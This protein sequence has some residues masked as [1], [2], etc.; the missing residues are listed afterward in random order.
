MRREV[1]QNSA[2]GV[3]LYEAVSIVDTSGIGVEGPVARH[4][5]DVSG[6]VGGQTSAAHPDARAF[7]VGGDA[8]GHHLLESRCV[9]A[10]NPAV[11]RLVV[12]VGRE[13]DV[14]HA[15]AQ[16]QC[17]P[18]V[19]QK[20]MERQLSALR[21]H[22]GPRHTCLNHHRPAELLGAGSDIE[23]MQPLHIVRIATDDF[24]GLG[25][26]VQRVARRINHR[27][28]GDADLGSD[29]ATLARIVGGNGG[30]A[31]GRIDEAYVPQRIAAQSVGI[32]GID[33]VMLRRHVDDIVEPLSRECSRW[34]RRAAKHMLYRP[35]G[36]RKA[37][38]IATSLRWPESIPFRS[39]S[40]RSGSCHCDG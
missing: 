7:T 21:S 31:G 9:I 23:S 18:L 13:S 4:E 14:N 40:D 29:I 34:P 24:L 10:Q 19:L 28:A 1:V 12:S 8:E 11:V 32:E 25:D 5:V 35:A 2:A 27:G 30:N 16:E 33:A 20:G 22:T 6:G 26:H 38:Q 15:V 17:R 37:F 36:T 39:G 3:D